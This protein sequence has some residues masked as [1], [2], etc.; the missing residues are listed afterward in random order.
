MR[1]PTDLEGL[2]RETYTP[3]SAK[4]SKPDV[5]SAVESI[6]RRIVS[7]GLALR[8]GYNEIARLKQ[9]LFERDIELA[10]DTTE[11]L[12]EIVERAARRQRRPWFSATS[13]STLTDAISKEC[14][15]SLVDLV[16]WWLIIYGVI[17][18]D[19]V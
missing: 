19:D 6:R 11:A 1:L 9:A 12:G 8:S 17:T 2:L 14:V 5:R 13:V 10:G 15:D 4:R 16:Y 18:F 7:K 3:R